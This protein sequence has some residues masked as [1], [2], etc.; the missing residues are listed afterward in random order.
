MK[1]KTEAARRKSREE[2]VVLM[3]DYEVGDLPQREFC[4]RHEVAYSTFGYWRKQLC[5][6]ATASERP[7]EP[8]LEL[9]SLVSNEN[10]E[11]RMELDLGSGMILRVR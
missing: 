8:F 11:W 1:E 4:E 7:S 6:P 3:A 2:W 10:T 9:P 5:S